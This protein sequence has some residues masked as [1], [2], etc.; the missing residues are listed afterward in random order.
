MQIAYLCHFSERDCQ[1]L[2]LITLVMK[3]GWVVLIVEPKTGL[4]ITIKILSKI[5]LWT[6]ITQLTHEYCDISMGFQ[7]LKTISFD[8]MYVDK[9]RLMSKVTWK[10]TSWRHRKKSILQQVAKLLL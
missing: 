8:L 6:V 4:F 7:K 9:Q 3:M 1:M 5:P 2:S 10:F